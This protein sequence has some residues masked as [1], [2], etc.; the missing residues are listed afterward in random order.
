MQPP[1]K[2]H[3]LLNKF[4]KGVAVSLLAALFFTF[5]L[6]IFARYA[7]DNS[8]GWTLE[9][10]LTLW[11]WLVFFGNAF[12]V[13]HRD[14]VTF[15]VLYRWVSKRTRRLFALIAAAAIAIS[16]ALAVLPTWDFIDFLKI[17]RSATLGVSMRVV[18]S[19]YMLF[20]F[21]TIVIYTV[22]FIRIARHGLPEEEEDVKEISLGD[23][24]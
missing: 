7:L 20:M 16:M 9:L 2:I 1:K 18:F 23:N 10:C 12:V 8:P 6:Q 11:V 5:I 13:R 22:R 15:D 19:V 3:T 17:K 4:S 14:H 21:A 24:R